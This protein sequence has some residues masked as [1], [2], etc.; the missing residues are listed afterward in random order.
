ML[1]IPH[2][3]KRAGNFRAGIFYRSLAVLLLRRPTDERCA[4]R[5]IAILTHTT[6]TTTIIIIIAVVRRRHHD[7]QPSSYRYH[8]LASPV[9]MTRCGLGLAKARQLA[10]ENP[11]AFAG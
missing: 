11:S 3:A 6:T 9:I 8:H 5:A 2:S 1:F 10:G 4:T 7:R